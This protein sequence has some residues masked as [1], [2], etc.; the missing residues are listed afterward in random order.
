[1][2]LKTTDLKRCYNTIKNHIGPIL[3]QSRYKALTVRN[4]G[5]AFKDLQ[6]ENSSLTNYLNTINNTGMNF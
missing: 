6:T 5:L 1:M 4:L 3:V 2:Y